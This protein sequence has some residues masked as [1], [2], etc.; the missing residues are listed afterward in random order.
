MYHADLISPTFSSGSSTGYGAHPSSGS[1]KD[2]VVVTK[3]AVKRVAS[4]SPPPVPT[5]SF[6]MLRE[7]VK[8]E[9]GY[10][11]HYP[12]PTEMMRAFNFSVTRDTSIAKSAV[13]TYMLELTTCGVGAGGSKWDQTG[14]TGNI[15][16]V[17]SQSIPIYPDVDVPTLLRAC[18]DGA[19]KTGRVSSG[20]YGVLLPTI[21]AEYL[22]LFQES[23]GTAVS[24]AAIPERT[25]KLVLEGAGSGG[26]GG[27]ACGV[28]AIKDDIE[29]SNVLMM[30]VCVLLLSL[31]IVF[32][33]SSFSRFGWC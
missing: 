18:R 28:C 20:G 27:G 5:F 4:C 6:T 2:E 16:T 23:S 10:I 8:E 25:R 1:V 9:E 30:H 33:S 3:R 24:A 15:K 11:V 29:K 12:F 31:L 26:G 21:D 13:L 14:G 19:V 17:E 32:V 22:H 7:I